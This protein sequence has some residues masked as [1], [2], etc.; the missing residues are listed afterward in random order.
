M[1][2]SRPLEFSAPQPRYESFAPFE[3]E[4]KQQFV[5]KVSGLN[6]ADVERYTSNLRGHLEVLQN[7][8]IPQGERILFTNKN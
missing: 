4:N 2:E 3:N 8:S 5:V 1:S 7:E 6:K